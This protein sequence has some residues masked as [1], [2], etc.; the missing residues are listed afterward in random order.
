MHFCPQVAYAKSYLKNFLR[1]AREKGLHKV[2]V[3]TGAG[4]HSGKGEGP[5]VKIAVVYM[6]EEMG[7]CFF[8]RSRQEGSF[9]VNL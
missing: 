3:I 1:T 5:R 6:L 7:L 9:V 2:E 4:Y 8:S